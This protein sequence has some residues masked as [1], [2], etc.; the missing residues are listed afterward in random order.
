MLKNRVPPRDTLESP[1]T[2]RISL[3]LVVSQ[4][5]ILTTER[6]ILRRWRDSDREAF[7]RMDA[8]PRVMEFFPEPLLRESSN[9]S[10]DRAEAH[11]REHGFGLCAAEFRDDGTFIGFIGLSIPSLGSKICVRHATG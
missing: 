1:I 8:D 11:F 9:A 7:A 5:P 4:T 3:S 2:I 10:V 6:L